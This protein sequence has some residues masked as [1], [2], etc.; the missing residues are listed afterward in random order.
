MKIT[1]GFNSTMT[2]RPGMGDKLI[3]LLLLGVNEGN[4]G[5]SEYCLVYL[6]SRS[7]SDP[8]VAHITEGWT[9]GEDHHR[10]F[11]SPAAKT[12]VAQ[13]RDLLASEPLYTDY[14]PVGGKAA[15]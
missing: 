10:I 8:D 5:S 6:V 11:D 14:V 3:E 15:L 12:I 9:T 2:A 13:F 1:Y 4:P 7:A